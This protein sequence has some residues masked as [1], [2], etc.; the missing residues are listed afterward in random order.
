MSSAVILPSTTASTAAAMG[1]STPV[2]SARA[3]S[4]LQDFAPS[5]TWR[6]EA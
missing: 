4:D 5:A 6:V 3:S 2:R 1:A